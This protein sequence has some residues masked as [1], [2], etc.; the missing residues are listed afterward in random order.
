MLLLLLLTVELH[1][2]YSRAT[3]TRIHGWVV[4]GVLVLVRGDCSLEWSVKEGKDQGPACYSKSLSS[5][6]FSLA[7][8]SS[9]FPSLFE[10][11]YV[12]TRY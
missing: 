2:I 8:S 6:L 9:L 10:F 3:W 12:C 7:L 11:L 5:S 1:E 4:E